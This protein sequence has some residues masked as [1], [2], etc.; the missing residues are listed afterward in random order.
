ML[1]PIFYFDVA[2]GFL[3]F[4]RFFIASRI[5]NQISSDFNR[6]YVDLSFV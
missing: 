3:I 4:S 1:Q 2:T 6:F 5:N